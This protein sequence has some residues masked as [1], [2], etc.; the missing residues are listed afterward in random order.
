MLRNSWPTQN[1]RHVFFCFGV[2]GFDFEGKK[3]KCCYVEGGG[4]SGKCWGRVKNMTKGFVCF[5]RQG[6]CVPL[7]PTLE[8]TL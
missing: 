4:E 1:G 5:S 7:V 8:L 6:F 3:R 2:F